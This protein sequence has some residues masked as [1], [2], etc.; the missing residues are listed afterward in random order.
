M[1][2][3]LDFSKHSVTDLKV[4]LKEM[5]LDE[6]TD[7]SRWI[8]KHVV[9][10]SVAEEFQAYVEVKRYERS[11]KRKDYRNG[12]RTRDLITTWGVIRNIRVPRTRGGGFQPRTF[13]RY[14]RVHPRVDEGVLKM[15]LMGVSTR[16]VADVL[17]SLFDYTLS[18]SY[19]CKVAKR[20]DG[21]VNR[22]FDR[23]LTDEFLYLF[24]DGIV[25]KV[26][27]IARSWKRTLLVAYGIRPDGSR[28]LIDFRVSK[29][30]GKGAWTSFLHNLQ[31]RGLRG[32]T[33]KLII[34][35]GG[36]GLW[37]ATE[38][39]FPFV[40]HQ[41]CWVHKLRNVAN[42]CP[43][44]YHR[45]C[46]AHARRIYLSP[47][48]KT[49]MRAFREWEKTWRHKAPN[50]VQCLAK[51]IDKLLP[52]LQCPLEHHRIVRT[53]NVIERLFRELRRRLK[54]M[55]TFPDSASC[56]R[57]TYAIFAYHNTRWT[58]TSYRIKKIALTY[59]QAA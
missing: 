38:E 6:M 9:E 51:D 8:V 18:A 42:R 24:L 31:V 47:T 26:K 43:Q 44:I 54:V 59:Q 22:F 55:G 37:A 36:A 40:P 34:T 50:A 3:Q 25:V 5:F 13:E 56:K 16:K 45:D 17:H 2:Q 35:D 14:K 1:L 28:Q 10:E 29:H 46:I 58:R 32:S 33:L 11:E 57:I 49:G 53:T 19:V 39:V 27:D 41:L 4:G 23:P 7:R 21:E 48:V 20:L 30:E 12:Y 52:F 15:F